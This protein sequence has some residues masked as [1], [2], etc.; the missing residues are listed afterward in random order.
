MVTTQNSTKTVNSN[1]IQKYENIKILY[2]Q[3]Y[4]KS[5]QHINKNLTIGKVNIQKVKSEE[6]RE[7]MNWKVILIIWVPK[8]K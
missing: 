8:E 2:L 6:R 3:F 4:K 1:S 7:I 5:I